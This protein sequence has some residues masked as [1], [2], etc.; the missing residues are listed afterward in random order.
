VHASDSNLLIWRAVKKKLAALTTCCGRQAD[1]SAALYGGRC[2]K[3]KARRAAGANAG[4]AR[5]PAWR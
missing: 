5:C 2:C 1:A 4:R 3:E